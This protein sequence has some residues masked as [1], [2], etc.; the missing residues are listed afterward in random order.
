M[1]LADIFR[2]RSLR[3]MITMVI[4]IVVAAS[5]ALTAWVVGLAS[6]TMLHHAVEAR[7]RLTANLVLQGVRETMLNGAPWRL[8]GTIERMKTVESIH[9][10]QI[11]DPSGLVKYDANSI[12]T[13]TM[14]NLGEYRSSDDG[15]PVL[16]T[17]HSHDG[18]PLLE[19]LLPIKIEKECRQCHQGT[20]PIIGYLNIETDM[21]MI[22]TQIADFR[23]ISIGALLLTVIGVGVA[24]SVLLTLLVTNPLK[25][26]ER[27]MQA[28]AEYVR[29]LAQES[30]LDLSGAVVP[31]EV[32]YE[33][34]KVAESFNELLAALERSHREIQRL[35]NAD[36]ERAAKMATIG[37]LA[38]SI[39]HEIRN[40]LAGILGAVEVIAEDLPENHPKRVVT[41]MMKGEIQRLNRTLTNLLSYARPRP[42][43]FK[44]MRLQSVAEKAIAFVRERA[45][46]QKVKLSYDAVRGVPEI[47]ADEDGMTQ[48]IMNILLNALDAMPEG[49]L[50]SIAITADAS[51]VRMEIKDGGPGMTQQVLASLF[52]PFFTT[53]VK[54]T[55]LGLAIS[56]RIVDSHGGTFDV[57]SRAGLGTTMTITLPVA[58]EMKEV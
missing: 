12:G 54:G 17:T 52:K 1:S 15:S 38:S 14:V 20:S 29:T 26:L 36:M 34:G 7:T 44:R 31:V 2:F 48:V 4:L 37:E 40:P 51:F 6:E 58:P 23:A 32:E 47:I 13:G 39:A 5:V 28:S 3:G 19:G 11:I 57:Q 35:H 42:L 8:R 33:V 24:L 30:D 46:R 18:M 50:L 10:I 22:K 27:R 45:A 55:G 41:D 16:Y 56:K 53:K 25:R 43:E 49:G 9:N 21:N